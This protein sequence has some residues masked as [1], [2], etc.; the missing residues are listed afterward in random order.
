MKK[1]LLFGYVI[2]LL[3]ITAIPVSAATPPSIPYN[4]FSCIIQNAPDDTVYID[5]LIKLTPQD[6]EYSSFNN[7]ETTISANSEIAL[8]NKDGYMS[9]FFHYNNIEAAG[10]EISK[11]WFYFNN[12]D[13]S[14]YMISPTIK[15]VL[16]DKDGNILQIS[17]AISTTPRKSE[18]AYKLTYD[19]AENNI[20]IEFEHY[21]K[22]PFAF[23]YLSIFLRIVLAAGIETL[24]AIPFKLRPI[25][26]I[27]VVNIITQFIYIIILFIGFRSLLILT[28][29]ILGEILFY[30]SEFFAY[31]FLY[32]S[33][34]KS[35]IVIFTIAANTATL[36]IFILMTVILALV[37]NR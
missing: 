4:Y 21:T 26:K 28:A 10:M 24:I 34:P 36:F 37:C 1:V 7:R 29:L 25:W 16:L 32:K 6:K 18:F 8:Y 13:L 15:A 19:A 22:H 31:R 5:I 33:S 12:S 30:V 23:L 20:T 14:I 9:L 35:E 11:S 17:E 2:F 27:S 3:C